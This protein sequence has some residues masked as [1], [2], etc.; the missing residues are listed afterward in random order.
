MSGKIADRPSIESLKA[1]IDRREHRSL[2]GR[3]VWPTGLKALDQQLAGGGIG[4]GTVVELF[5][6]SESGAGAWRLAFLML[7]PMIERGMGACFD[8]KGSLYPPA[9]AAMGVDLK[10]LLFLKTPE[11]RQALWALEQIAGNSSVV[12]TLAALDRLKTGDL[13]RLQLAVEHSGSVLIL[14]R[15]WREQSWKGTG[16]SM[17]LAVAM[18]K[19]S[20]TLESW[21]RNRSLVVELLRCRGMKGRFSPILVELDGVTG[22]VS[23]SSL[24]SR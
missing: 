16:A 1:L 24:L 7:M 22:S 10:R 11:F 19:E 15:P 21:K 20:E 3:D 12:V 13:R 9:L 23:S 2:Q 4:R 5:Y 18:S 14:L 17:K 6:E 8:F